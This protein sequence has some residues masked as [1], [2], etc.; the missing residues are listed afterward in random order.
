MSDMMRYFILSLVLTSLYI[1][2]REHISKATELP[3]DTIHNLCVGSGGTLNLVINSQEEF[4]AFYQEW[5][6]DPLAKWLESNYA[7][8]LDGVRKNYPRAT[9]DQYDSIIRNDYIYNFA[10]F[11]G[12]QNCEKPVVDFSNKTLLAQSLQIS[13]C[14]CLEKIPTTIYRNGNTITVQAYPEDTGN[15]EMACYYANF[16][17]IDKIS[18]DLVVLFQE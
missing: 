16:Y 10:P 18:P 15:C 7:A 8:L 4:D 9:E 13:G 14:E 12:T 17:T 6:T 11:K 2:C 5:H 1:S 3:Y